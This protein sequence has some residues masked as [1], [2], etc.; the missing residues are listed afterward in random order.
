MEKKSTLK[1][2][3]IDKKEV[4]EEKWFKNGKKWTIMMKARSDTL[5]L[6]W[7]EWGVNEEKECLLCRGGIEDLQHFLL[8]CVKL[9]NVRSK[10]LE[11]MRPRREDSELIMRIILMMNGCDRQP[12]Y[13]VNLIWDLWRER[14]RLIEMRYESEN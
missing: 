11:L 8:D 9:E 4:G 7:R 1:L 6:R 12:V 3:R 14:G 5:K 2:Y 13:Y 10:Y